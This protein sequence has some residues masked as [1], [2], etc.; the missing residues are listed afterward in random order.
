MIT[1]WESTYCCNQYN[2]GVGVEK[3]GGGSW[4][5]V[6]FLLFYNQS[7]NTSERTNR[8]LGYL[9]HF[10]STVNIFHSRFIFERVSGIEQCKYKRDFQVSF[11]EHPFAYINLFQ[12]FR[13]QFPLHSH[14]KV[15]AHYQRNFIGMQNA[16]LSKHLQCV[17]LV[18]KWVRLMIRSPCVP[19][20][21]F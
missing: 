8:R 10:F 3:G 9:S 4:F 12:Y 17:P 7:F 21:S 11:Y 16:L 6:S 20:W 15:S 19:L 1:E 13:W 14:C 5:H 18:N 2:C